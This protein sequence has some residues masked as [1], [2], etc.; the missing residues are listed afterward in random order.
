MLSSK[1]EETATIYRPTFTK[2][3]GCHPSNCPILEQDEVNVRLVREWLT[4]I[5]ELV[6]RIE[7]TIDIH[8]SE[9]RRRKETAR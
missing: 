1:K 9:V 4:S 7:T 2:G 3:S 8:D 6:V 5:R